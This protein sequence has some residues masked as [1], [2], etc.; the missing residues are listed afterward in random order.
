MSFY[1]FLLVIK[2]RYKVVLLVLFGVMAFGIAMS[3]LLPSKYTAKTTLVVD[4][5]S[6]DPV[7][8]K[9]LPS[10]MMMPG[11]MSTQ[12]DIITSDRVVQKAAQLLQLDKSPILAERWRKETKGRGDMITW[13]GEVLKKDLD[14]KPSRESD[15]VAIYFTSRDPAFSAAVAN[16]IGQAYI[17]TNLDLKVEPAKQYADW[18][19]ERIKGLRANLEDAQS[20]LADFQQKTGLVDEDVRNPANVK[21]NQL[22]AQLANAETQSAETQSKAMHSSSGDTMPD[23]MQNPVVQNLKTQIYDQEGRLQE[24]GRNVGRN[25]PDY[26]AL[27]SQIALLKQ[28]L[29]TETRRVMGSIATANSVNKQKERELQAAIERRKQQVLTDN[30]DRDQIA[31]LE[32]DVAAAQKAYDFALQQYAQN[33]LESQ[34]TQT[35]ITVL[36]SAKPPIVRSS[37]NI[38]LN[39][40]LSVFFGTILGAAAA[41]GAEMSDRRIRSDVELHEGTGVPLLAHIRPEQEV[42]EGGSRGLMGMFQKPR[43]AKGI[44]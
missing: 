26:Q 39:L 18:F 20:K 14:V 32:N 30:K 27:E 6:V 5:K 43:L 23:V 15:M 13:L 36:T 7:S 9:M 17:D 40:I 3:F 10:M 33:S 2:S 25:N 16:A 35:N 34:S 4:I 28:K 41:F 19:S 8:G 42:K 1:Q 44:A 11:Y 12:S 31:V 37:P 38:F 22:T 21:L 24:L 29:E